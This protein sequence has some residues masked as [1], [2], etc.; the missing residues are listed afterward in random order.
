[1]SKTIDLKI[2]GMTCASC[3]GR[4]EKYL[5][6]N[7]A[8]S[9]AAVNLATEKARVTYDEKQTNEGELLKNVEQAGF[10]GA[11]IDSKTSFASAHKNKARQQ[12]NEKRLLILSTLL[13]LPLVLPM[14]L[15]PFDLHL[16]P[17]AWAQLLLATPVQFFIGARFYRAGFSA[18][19]AKTGNMELLVALGTSA[20]F[21]LSLYLMSTHQAGHELHLYFE[22]SAVIITLVLFGKY[23]ESGAKRQTASAIKALEKLRPTKARI[24]IDGKTQERAL[25]EVKVGDIVVTLPGERIAM[26]AQIIQGTSSVD[27]SLIT[28]ESL[29]QY[30]SVGDVIIAGAQN[31]DGALHAKVSALGAQSMLSKII[32]MVENAQMHKAPVQ[33]LVDKVAAVFVPAVLVIALVTFVAWGLSNGDWQSALI[34]AVAVMVIACPCALGLATP[35]SIMV[36]TGLAAKYGILIKDAGALEKSHFIE[37]IAFDKTGTLTKGEPIVAELFSKNLEKK[38]LIKLLASIQSA[39]EHPLAKAVLELAKKENVDYS[40]AQNSKTLPGIG[41]EADIANKAYQLGSSRLLNEYTEEMGE[42]PYLKKAKEREELGESVSFLVDKDSKQVIGLVSFSDEVRESSISA[43]KGLKEQGIATIMITGDNH[44]AAKNMAKLIG[45]DE[46]K[47]QVLPNEKA[48]AIKE[49][50]NKYGTVAMVGDGIN[51]APALA[52]ADI[53]IAMSS[54]SDIALEAGDIVL[55]RSNPLLIIDSISLSKKTYQKIKQNLFWAFFYNI[56]GIPLA[57]LGFLNPMIA[58]AAMA[59]SSVSVVGNSLLLK[60][61]RS[62]S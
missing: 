15:M 51:D 11:V 53:G 14:L 48:Q 55:M 1:M 12:Q 61:W 56:L 54:G 21:F 9:D 47:S 31:I 59:F 30:K 34:N 6:K 62:R 60:R 2:E 28:G 5:K 13:T 19:K 23:M 38:E 45:I 58:G 20:A 46:I 10:K 43:I 3:V 22:S 33:R 37:A 36:G 50:K 44:A 42:G 49:L 32:E 18:L 7:T 26:D 24:L 16:M 40:Q 4:V 35:T 29:P 57:A 8:V 39:S 17:P 52:M 27:E 25:D 41:I